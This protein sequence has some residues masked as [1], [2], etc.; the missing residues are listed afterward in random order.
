MATGIVADMPIYGLATNRVMGIILPFTLHAYGGQ[1]MSTY[2]DDSMARPSHDD[3]TGLD[4]I[5]ES[6][7]TINRG[8]SNPFVWLLLIGSIFGIPVTGGLS[9][10]LAIV[11]LLMM[12]GGGKAYVQAIPPAKAD[13]VAPKAGCIRI[14]AA[15]GSLIIFLVV[16]ALFLAVLAY[17][18]QGG[19]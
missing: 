11:A 2:T 9:I 7:E 15:T 14:V 1:K 3:A 6:T 18:A 10:G 4:R 16:V 13:I 17:K 19:V 12:T 5:Q 8:M